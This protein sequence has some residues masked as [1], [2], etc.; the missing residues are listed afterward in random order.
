ME[1]LHQQV[2]SFEHDSTLAQLTS[3]LQ[4][5]G[6]PCIA[7]NDYGAVVNDADTSLQVVSNLILNGGWLHG[8]VRIGL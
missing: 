4:K 8:R 2:L 6:L 5:N 3:L 7:H 1:S